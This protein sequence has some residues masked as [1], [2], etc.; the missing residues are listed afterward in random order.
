MCIS[1]EVSLVALAVSGATCIW[2]W[3]RNRPH[4]DR[5]IAIFSGYTGLMQLLEFTI[6]SDQNCGQVNM[7]STQIAFFHNL[8]QPVVSCM[9]A[10]WF[11]EKGLPLYSSCIM[12]LW[13][14]IYVPMHLQQWRDDMCTKACGRAENQFGLAFP[15]TNFSNSIP[16][17]SQRLIPVYWMLFA[18][19]LCTPFWN[20]KHTKMYCILGLTTWLIAY[21]ISLS[22]PCDHTPT[23]SSWWCLLGTVVPC[24]AIVKRGALVHESP[25]KQYTHVSRSDESDCK[26]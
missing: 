14:A 3:L 1:R 15:Y 7:I 25:P 26:I 22:H 18:F 8:L 10:W 17:D 4:H 9:A 20:G 11:C 13:V 2:L 12:M 21:A 23:V 16:T 5:W 19:A 24:V 6:W